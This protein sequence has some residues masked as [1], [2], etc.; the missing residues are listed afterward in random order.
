MAPGST[1]TTTLT[2]AD[3]DGHAASSATS[4]TATSV[5]DAPTVS[6]AH[7]STTNDRTADTALLSNVT[8]SDPDNPAQAETATIR[9]AHGAGA[10]TGAGAATTANGVDTYTLQATSAST[11]ST[12]LGAVT[13]QPTATGAGPSTSTTFNLTVTD[14]ADA[15]SPTDANTVVTVMHGPTRP[16]RSGA[17]PARPRKLLRV[18]WCWRPR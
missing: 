4:V 14:A 10:L 5:N 7:A 17:S 13:F 16:L 18:R 3:D 2:F 8:V 1:V 12:A 9:F 15:S 11:L 6:G